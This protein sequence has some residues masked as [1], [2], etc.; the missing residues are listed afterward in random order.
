MTSL[1]RITNYEVL[2]AKRNSIALSHVIGYGALFI[3]P[4]LF[5]ILGFIHSQGKGRQSVDS[6]ALADRTF[7]WLT[8]SLVMISTWICTGYMFGSAESVVTPG[9]GLVWTQAP[10]AFSISF[11]VNSFLFCE[12]LRAKDMITFLD[13][14]TEKFGCFITPFLYIASL[15]GDITWIAMLVHCLGIFV[16]IVVGANRVIAVGYVCLCCILIATVRGMFSLKYAGVAEFIVMFVSVLITFPFIRW[17]SCVGSLFSHR[18]QWLGTV[19]SGEWGEWL[20]G[21]FLIIF[22]GTCWQVYFQQML[23]CKTIEASHTMSLLSGAGTFFFGL[24]ACLAGM[25]ASTVDWTAF[26]AV[27]SLYQKEGNVMCY[28]L[29]YFLPVFPRAL[30]IAG[31]IATIMGS[32]SGAIHSSATVFVLNIY[33]ELRPRASDKECVIVLRVF[34]VVVAVLGVGASRFMTSV[35]G[36]WVFTSEL[37]F[38]F[39]FPQLLL[40]IWL[41]KYVNVYGALAAFVVGATLHF[42]IGVEL[43]QEAGW[44][45]NWLP[46]RTMV[47]VVEMG[48]EVVVSS[49][50]WY[51]IVRRDYTGIDC[52]HAFTQKAFKKSRRSARRPCELHRSIKPLEGHT[53]PCTSISCL[54]VCSKQSRHRNTPAAGKTPHTPAISIHA[55]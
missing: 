8:G 26:P 27:G 48:V 5:M 2:Y 32:F 30:S 21:S 37:M 34:I 52:L 39:V 24:F 33:R 28:V 13:P 25:L 3:T 36:S 31:I 44:W 20:D 45:P 40:V 23:S 50:F 7:T 17:N 54:G 38:I 18:D 41:S 4:L 9:R 6:F 19:K 14:L 11:I 35:Y 49:I 46:F 1:F 51:L 47:V 43:A 15:V 10:W 53:N 22:G 29:K 12:Q 16:A 42:G 55:A